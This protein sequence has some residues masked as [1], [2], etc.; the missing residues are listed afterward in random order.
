[1]ILYIVNGSVWAVVRWLEVRWRLGGETDGDDAIQ[2]IY[3]PSEYLPSLSMAV[4][5]I[6]GRFLT[7]CTIHRPEVAVRRNV[8]DGSWDTEE[9][10]RGRGTPC[11]VSTPFVPRHQRHKWVSTCTTL[12]LIVSTIIYWPTPTE[13][14]AGSSKAH[15][16]LW[17]RQ[18]QIEKTYQ[19]LYI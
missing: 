17:N 9:G 3:P 4:N 1:M 10:G 19:E 8:P 11:H 18:S 14:Q 12:E 7:I 15:V 5:I 16:C 6:K 13:L 2:L